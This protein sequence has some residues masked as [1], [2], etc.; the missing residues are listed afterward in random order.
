MAYG[1][2]GKL[3]VATAISGETEN[4]VGGS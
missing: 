1:L 3:K 2:P 4:L